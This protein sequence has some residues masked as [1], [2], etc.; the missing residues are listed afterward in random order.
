MDEKDD[1]NDINLKKFH[2]ESEK[3]ERIKRKRK[4]Y[5]KEDNKENENI[6][7]IQEKII[8]EEFNDDKIQEEIK[9]E[10]LKQMK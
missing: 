1:N 4:L 5:W 2:C 9:E 3:E 8:N 7:N 6:K 10:K